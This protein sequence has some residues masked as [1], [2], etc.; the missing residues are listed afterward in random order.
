MKQFILKI[1][2]FLIVLAFAFYLFW[3][4][5]CYNR[6]SNMKLPTSER[7]VFLGNSHIECA[8]NDTILKNS[9]NFGRSAEPMECIYSKTKLLQRYN[10][11]LDTIII[12]FDN[13]LLCYGSDKGIHPKLYSPYYFDT[14][15]LTDLVQMT[16]NGSFDFIVSHLYH[17]FHYLKLTDFIPS[18]IGTD[19]NIH[20]LNALGGFL[21]L[22]RDK[23]EIAIQRIEKSNNNITHYDSLACYF[24]DETIKFC[25]ENDITVI[26]LLPP[27][28]HKCPLDSTY[29]K[30][31]Y[32]RYYSDIPFYDF[33]D[34]A[35][36]DSCFGDLDHLNH[37]GAAVFSEYLER[38]VFHK[39]NYPN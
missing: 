39:N 26:F 35:L 27:Q 12:G 5:T 25:K 2:A 11:H 32:N 30:H 23:L 3:A 20:D 6:S 1:F 19:C 29:Y 38:N 15:T 18:Y 28:H 21:Y 14:Y 34:M 16:I 36:P 13:Y 17:P 4:L 31:H 10:P 22:Y 37:K 7:I 33:R 24:L 8:I 9:F